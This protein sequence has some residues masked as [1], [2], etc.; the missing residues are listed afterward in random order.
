[1]TPEE[2]NAALKRIGSLVPGIVFERFIMVLTQVSER[3]NNKLV[4]AINQMCIDESDGF[5]YNMDT[6]DLQ[7]TIT[8]IREIID[9][10]DGWIFTATLNTEHD[11][12][13][14]HVQSIIGKVEY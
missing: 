8:P 10:L 6:G 5:W 12:I 14:W 1:M 11:R 3:N 7:D 13:Q 9:L 4:E 2:R